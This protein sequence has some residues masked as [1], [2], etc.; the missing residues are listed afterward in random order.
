MIA[1][2]L[3]Q[4][5]FNRAYGAGSGNI[6][7]GLQPRESQLQI[8]TEYEYFSSLIQSNP[9]K[10]SSFCFTAL[11]ELLLSWPASASHRL[12]LGFG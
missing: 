4:Q 7:K 3:F 8:I 12:L 2:W 5:C 6:V 11:R 9:L 10:G 1:V